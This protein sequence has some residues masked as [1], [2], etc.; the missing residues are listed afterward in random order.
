VAGLPL[1]ERMARFWALGI[2]DLEVWTWRNMGPGP[3]VGASCRSP[4]ICSMVLR[5][6]PVGLT[7]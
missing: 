2:R 1:V 5:H 7:S 4:P 6:V 3:W